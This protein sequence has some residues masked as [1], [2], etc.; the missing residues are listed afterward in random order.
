MFIR[1]N[2]KRGSLFDYEIV[3]RQIA[4]GT[5]KKIL[6]NRSRVKQKKEEKETHKI[7]DVFLLPTSEKFKREKNFFQEQSPMLSL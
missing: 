5:K 4:V 6:K 7:E 3:T 1:R 2:C